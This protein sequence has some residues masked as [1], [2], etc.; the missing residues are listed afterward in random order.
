MGEVGYGSPRSPI[1][2][3]PFYRVHDLSPSPSSP[4]NRRPQ[5]LSPSSFVPFTQTDGSVF[6]SPGSPGLYLEPKLLAS[7][8]SSELPPGVDPCRREVGAELC[9]CGSNCV[10]FL[11][12]VGMLRGGEDALLYGHYRAQS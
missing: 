9:V 2:P 6:P 11:V 8:A 12:F 3:S 4:S 10:S 5:S 7:K 1:S